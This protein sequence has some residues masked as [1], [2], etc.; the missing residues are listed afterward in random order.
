MQLRS[1][2]GVV[3]RQNLVH[4]QNEWLGDGLD[5]ASF[6]KILAMIV[7]IVTSFRYRLGWA[8][9]S[10]RSRG[11]LILENLAL[12]QQLPALHA[13][14]PRRRMTTLHKLFW[15][16]LRRLWSEWERPL[17]LVTPR[18]VVGWHRAGFRLYLTWV[19]R[20]RRVGGRRRVSKEVRALILRMAAENPDLGSAADPRR[21]PQAGF[22]AVRNNSLAMGSK[23]P[24]RSTSRRMLAHVPQESS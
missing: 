13:K 22:Q 19:S 16:V 10:L 24:E 5:G 12:R 23:S 20:A 3:P 21:T 1:S 15:V 8:V 6:D 11:D 2:G 17:I 4:S 7:A 14:Q 9:S 18:T